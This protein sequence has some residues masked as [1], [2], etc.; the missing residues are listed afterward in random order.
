MN[1][2]AVLA[3]ALALSGAGNILLWNM[4]DAALEDK[5]QAEAAAHSAQA[6]GKLCSENTERLAA[7]GEARA[8]AAA[9]ALA[10]AQKTASKAQARALVTLAA[11]PSDPGDACKSADALNRQQIEARRA[12]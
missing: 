6:A 4:R 5:A 3:I 1:L 2:L 12:R 7:E 9:K 8:E 11:P 10:A